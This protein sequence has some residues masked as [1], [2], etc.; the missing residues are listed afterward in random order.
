MIRMAFVP[1]EPAARSFVGSIEV[2]APVTAALRRRAEGEERP[3]FLICINLLSVAEPQVAHLPGVGLGA[4]RSCVEADDRS[5]RQSLK[6]KALANTGPE[7]RR[8]KDRMQSKA[9]IIDLEVVSIA[10]LVAWLETRGYGGLIRSA[11]TLLSED[12][13]PDLAFVELL[14][15]EKEGI[16]TIMALRTRWPDLPIIAMCQSLRGIPASMLLD[17]ALAL[18]ADA[19]LA[20]PPS[21]EAFDRAFDQALAVRNTSFQTKSEAGPPASS[22][23]DDESATS[24]GGAGNPSA[25]SRFAA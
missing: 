22:R 20:K 6:Q 4:A 14:N 3:R 17:F 5:A 23:P 15:P 12:A 2:N 7:T 11:A 9:V 24:L 21:L 16:E 1:D 25:A 13:S 18:G 10:T 8:W 19:A